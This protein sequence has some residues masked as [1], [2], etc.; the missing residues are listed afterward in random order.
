MACDLSFLVTTFNPETNKMEQNVVSLGLQ[1][2]RDEAVSVDRVVEAFTALSQDQRSQ[3]VSQLKKAKRQNI[4]STMLRQPIDLED[5][6]GQVRLIGNTTLGEL[7][8]QYPILKQR[9]HLN[10]D[11]YDSYT[12]IQGS[13]VKINNVS[14][15][16]RVILPSGQEVFVIKDFGAA[17][18]F[19]KYLQ[20]KEMAHKIFGEDGEIPDSIKPYMEDL[21]SI[22]GSDTVEDLVINYLNDKSKI[23]TV[24]RKGGTPIPSKK[25]L[26]K[27]MSILTG[28]YNA[29]GQLSDMEAAMAEVKLQDTG[30]DWKLKKD[31]M[32]QILSNFVPDFKD[33][34]SKEQFNNMSAAELSTL[35]TGPN[36][37]FRSHPKL[38]RAQ[39][40]EVTQGKKTIKQPEVT[41]S[42]IKKTVPQTTMKLIWDEIR[43]QAEARGM[44][45]PEK[46]AAY[47]KTDPQGVADLFNQAKFQFIPEGDTEYR[48]IEADI[49]SGKRGT[50][51][52]FNYKY[53]VE[54]QP[55][56]DEG[57]SH[58]TL[59]FP[60]SLMGDIYGF[61]YDT[62]HLFSPVTSSDFKDGKYKGFYVYKAMIDGK[63]VY[64][65]GRNLISPYSYMATY[66]TLEGALYNIDKQ[67]SQAKIKNNSLITIKQQEGLPRTC[68]VE[69]EGLH[70]GQILSVRDVELPVIKS[71]AMAQSIRSLFD[72]TVP[73]FHEL[74][75]E[76][77]GIE[78][79]QTPEDIAA[80]IYLA[81]SQITRD[82]AQQAEKE[83]T[84]VYE[85]FKYEKYKE[86]MADIID[87]QI[88]N[89][90][91]KHYYV[92]QLIH[93]KN[94][95]GA[96]IA[97]LRYLND[98]G[99]DISLD[100]SRVG[101]VSTQTFLSQSL[102]K[103]INFLNDQYGIRVN[104]LT[105]TELDELNTKNGW[106]LEKSI[107]V[108]KGFV[109]N[110]EIYINTSTAK[111]SDL[112]H[113]VSHLFMGV[114]KTNY[115]EGYMA[116][117]DQFQNGDKYKHAF[118]KKFEYIKQNYSKFALQDQIEETVAEM[119]GNQIM[120]DGRL[121]TGFDN[122]VMQN[123][124]DMIM[125]TVDSFANDV[126]DN[127]M[128]FDGFM[129]SLLSDKTDI[130]TKRRGV[131]RFIEQKIDQQ[132]I[133]EHNC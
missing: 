17:M 15:N 114:L 73:K 56:V 103:A 89:K 57:V 2:E 11:L 119:I 82:D 25:I 44:S 107:G 115:T 110:G 1:V 7:L 78:K 37:L 65:I 131:S 16:G 43:S 21:Q 124:I 72:L 125:S 99:T 128:G 49:I 29:D 69:Q 32:Y 33:M 48:T 26:G 68:F 31:S 13:S 88:L 42:T 132:Q 111:M 50:R 118:K 27:V 64:A 47:M 54:N 39:I 122:G 40:G 86:L 96:P 74:F 83:T 127:G 24:F 59:T 14:Y 80:F 94:R 109:H 53:E 34:V 130:L 58:I 120:S 100:G 51:V 81:N 105:A 95:R 112:F 62:Q 117:L 85:A 123:L 38:A 106:G 93:Q 76:I 23:K 98:G 113:E 67:N 5:K 46:F 10:T 22:A 19:V 90:P 28:E 77:E 101:D 104:A 8:G 116:L 92:E 108:I 121:T 70:E 3:I 55:K 20:A 60:Y 36:G 52:E 45:L 129:K 79:L 18:N 61:G 84:K 35:L 66:P 30:Y 71:N 102:T 12:I 75:S 4:T 87:N 126:N 41:Y 97:T 91:I 9:Y 133:Q 63:E 6:Q